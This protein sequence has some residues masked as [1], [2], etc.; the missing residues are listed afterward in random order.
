MNRHKSAT[1]WLL[2]AVVILGAVVVGRSVVG[3]GAD[4]QA[5]AAEAPSM[6]EQY[7]NALS[8]SRRQQSLIDAEEAWSRKL[9]DTRS[10]WNE[11][12]RELV[13]GRTV[14][15]A[16]AGF[17]QRILAEVKDFKFTDG[18]A[19]SVPVTPPAQPSGAVAAAQSP[20]GALSPADTAQSVRAIA[21]RVEVR[22]DTPAEVYRLIDRIENL[23]DARAGVVSV[24]VRGPGLAQTPSEVSATLLV[25]AVALIGEDTP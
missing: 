7:L 17:R 8:L 3:S 24:Q 13:R 25:H 14:E 19:N 10:A 1:P 6:R 12:S 15:L 18:S 4:D 11:I 5:D 16:E 22:T 21:L 23:P 20:P 9:A 2:A